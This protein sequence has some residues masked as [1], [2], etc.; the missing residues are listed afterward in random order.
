MVAPGYEACDDGA[1][2]GPPP[3]NCATTCKPNVG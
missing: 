3:A 2:N 1:N